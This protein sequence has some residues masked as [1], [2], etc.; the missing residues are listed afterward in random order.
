MGKN[1]L[2]P[3]DENILAKIK[4]HDWKCDTHGILSL[5]QIAVSVN[6]LLMCDFCSINSEMQ[7]NREIDPSIEIVLEHE[8]YERIAEVDNE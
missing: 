5:D 2:Y 3:E 8:K 7:P 4:K 1:E 6:G